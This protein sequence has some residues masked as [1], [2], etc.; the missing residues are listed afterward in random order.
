MKV[1]YVVASTDEYLAGMPYS[2]FH[3]ITA[4]LRLAKGEFAMEK[5]KDYGEIVE[6]AFAGKTIVF[7]AEEEYPF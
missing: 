3:G 5:L 7:A 1:K 4:C 2:Q 6:A